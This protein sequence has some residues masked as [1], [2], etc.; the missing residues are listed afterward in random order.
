[1]SSQLKGIIKEIKEYDFTITTDLDNEIKF[2]AVD[3]S[4]KDYNVGSC[5]YVQF[6]VKV[7]P[8]ED[9][10]LVSLDAFKVSLSKE[11]DIENNPEYLNLPI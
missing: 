2:K 5:V 9:R 3:V 10:R 11:N 6:N 7:L 4:L 8:Y 1:M